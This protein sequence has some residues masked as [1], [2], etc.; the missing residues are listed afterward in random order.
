[1]GIPTTVKKY[2]DRHDMQYA[3][4]PHPYTETSMETAEAAHV[5][6]ERIAKGVLLRDEHGFVLAVLPATHSLRVGDLQQMMDRRLE[7][8]AEA[9]VTRVFNDCAPGAVPALGPAYG[10]ETIVDEI[11]TEQPE[12]YFE[13]GDHEDLLQVSE[14]GFEAM[15]G[16]AR[17]AN[18]SSHRP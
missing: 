13:A 8:A 11:L 5:S 10:L 18:I 14:A 7:L 9:D 16:N 17:Y 2:L 6:G 4:V 15:I 1:M 12:L 3:V